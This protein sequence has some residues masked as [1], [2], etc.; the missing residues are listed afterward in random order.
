VLDSL[1]AFLP[2]SEQK[3]LH[4]LRGFKFTVIRVRFNDFKILVKRQFTLVLNI[5]W[6]E[7]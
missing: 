6:K 3:N 1:K 4:Q 7:N 5:K 2:K